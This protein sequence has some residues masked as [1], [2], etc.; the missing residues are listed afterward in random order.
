MM[1][2]ELIVEPPL[3]GNTQAITTLVP[4][5]VVVGALGVAGIDDART[6]T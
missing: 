6:V 4:S 2:A 3:S 5:T 1:V